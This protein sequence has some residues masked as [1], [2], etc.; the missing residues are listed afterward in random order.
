MNAQIAVCLTCT[1]PPDRC[2]NVGKGRPCP[3]TQQFGRQKPPP[4]L[5]QHFAGRREPVAEKLG[6]EAIYRAAMKLEREINR[7]LRAAR[8]AL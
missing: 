4:V 1:Q 8:A 7:N 5:M 3:Y 6:H 2:D